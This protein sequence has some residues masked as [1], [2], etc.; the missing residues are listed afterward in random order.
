MR[1]AFVHNIYYIWLTY[2]Q[3][4]RPR[5]SNKTLYVGDIEADIP[6]ARETSQ[7]ET[8]K[9]KNNHLVLI[10]NISNALESVKLRQFNR[11][12]S[13]SKPSPIV[14]SNFTVQ[15]SSQVQS[16]PV[17]VL[18]YVLVFLMFAKLLIPRYADELK[19]KNCGMIQQITSSY[20]TSCICLPLRR[21][22]LSCL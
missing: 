6:P 11:K 19:R 20:N 2:R 5:F 12:E 8:Q 1:I 14:Q 17:H 18:Y 21:R 7:K 3:Q 10:K 13:H 4:I 9:F 22:S 15:L 16:S